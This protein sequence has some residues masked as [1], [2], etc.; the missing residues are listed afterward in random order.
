MTQKIQ[1]TDDILHA[2]VDGQLSDQ[3]RNAVEDFLNENPDRAL[4][5]ADWAEQ[6]EVIRAL[7]PETENLLNVSLPAHSK[8]P[9]WMAIA[10]SITFL[11]I[12]VGLGWYGHSRFNNN[13]EHVAT[14]VQE[15]V[16]A[17]AVYSIDPHRPVEIAANEEA[18]LV[19][20][21]SKR[22]G[23][24][25]AAP[26]LSKQGFDLVGGRLLSVMEGPAAQFMYQDS[27]GQRITLFAVKGGSGQMASFTYQEDGKTNSFYWEDENLRYAIIGDIAR[28]TLNILAVQ[29]YNQ[30]S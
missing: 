1:I 9:P 26:D 3:E 12:G 23:S 6:N 19:R 10:A 11:W 24:Q 21:L 14:I 8:S 27:K 15:A 25:L 16:A 17:H 20:W 13:V 29:I 22:V 2:F 4:E 18:L 7:F 5:V 30:L 28:A